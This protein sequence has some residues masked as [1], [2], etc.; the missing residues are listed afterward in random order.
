MKQ[1]QHG[2]EWIQVQLMGHE[3]DMIWNG[4]MDNIAGNEMQQLN[5]AN[6]DLLNG[7]MQK[8]QEYNNMEWRP[9]A[10]YTMKSTTQ[11]LYTHTHTH[12]HPVLA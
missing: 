5:I 1:L 12:T 6:R 7:A 9:L 3:T 10:L 2:V 8:E 11:R 4:D